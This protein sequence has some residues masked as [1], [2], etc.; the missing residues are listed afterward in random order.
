MREEFHLKPLSTGTKALDESFRGYPKGAI[1]YLYAES[2]DTWV[3]DARNYLGYRAA[4]EALRDSGTVIWVDFNSAF[5]PEMARRAGFD[6]ESPNFLLV[7]SQTAEQALQ[8]VYEVLSS[9]VSPG[10]SLVILEEPRVALLQD[11]GE[12]YYT[13]AVKTFWEKGIAQMQNL[14]RSVDSATVV[15]VLDCNRRANQEPWTFWRR[16]VEL[17]LR[18][19]YQ[20]QDARERSHR[21]RVEVEKDRNW[22]AD[23]PKNKHFNPIHPQF[24]LNFPGSG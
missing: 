4:A 14:L 22:S 18:L 21:F 9:E 20:R 16:Y 10:V 3:R 15:L 24:I 11:P 23:P 12:G 13:V 8:L 1:S 5:L 6:P 2:S 19:C 7:Q 17:V